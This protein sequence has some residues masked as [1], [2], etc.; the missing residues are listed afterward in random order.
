MCINKEKA[1]TMYVS[2]ILTLK[3][4]MYLF[5]VMEIQR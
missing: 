5:S 2:P 4:A 3:G 1:T